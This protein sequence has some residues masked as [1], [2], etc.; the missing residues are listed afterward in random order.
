MTNN[1]TH[2]SNSST[3]ILTILLSS[4]HLS[5]S[6][7]IE[8]I[9]LSF[10]NPSIF[11]TTTPRPNFFPL[12]VG[13]EPVGEDGGQEKGD[14]T[15]SGLFLSD[16]L[17]DAI[18]SLGGGYLDAA[19][20]RN[21]AAK[22]KMLEDTIREEKEAIAWRKEKG[23]TSEGEGDPG[24]KNMN[25]FIGFVDD[26]YEGSSGNDE[27]GGWGFVPQEEEKEEEVKDEPKLFLFGEDDDDTLD[28]KLIL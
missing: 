9:S 27:E 8:A 19:K 24:P 20:K 17:N 6:F 12:F 14:E 7:T 16:D 5:T 10:V 4:L 28:K 23:Y 15:N 3:I 25:E 13:S 26:G 18:S 2:N 21:E 1:G 22:K 11:Q